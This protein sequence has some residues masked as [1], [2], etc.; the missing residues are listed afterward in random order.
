MLRRV[1]RPQRVP[2][3]PDLIQLL[4]CEHTPMRPVPVPVPVPCLFRLEPSRREFK[5]LMLSPEPPE[6]PCQVP[7]VLR[8]LP[9]LHQARCRVLVVFLVDQAAEACPSLN[10][11]PPKTPS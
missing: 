7:Q 11:G 3:Q 9:V 1:A 5:V 8:P 6:V 10:K 2:L 4:K